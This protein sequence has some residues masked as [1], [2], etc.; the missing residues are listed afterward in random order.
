MARCFVSDWPKLYKRTF[1][2]TDS[3][4]LQNLIPRAERAVF[5]RIL[6][7]SQSPNG[8]GEVNELVTAYNALSRLKITLSKKTT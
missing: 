4:E 7:L 6:E 2:E 8:A 5:E 1:L 3:T